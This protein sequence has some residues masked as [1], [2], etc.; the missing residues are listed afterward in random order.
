MRHGTAI[1]LALSVAIA[2]P[3]AASEAPSRPAIDAPELARLGDHAVGVS[4]LELVDAARSERR[5]AIDLWYPADVTA[6][7]APET[8]SGSLTAE[9]PAP[10]TRFTRPGIAVRDA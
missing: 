8:Y 7:A 2:M 3:L 4:T 9:P 6:G 10:P 1:L 5:L